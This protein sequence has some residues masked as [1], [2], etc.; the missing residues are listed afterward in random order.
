VITGGKPRKTPQLAR[1]QSV[2]QWAGRLKPREWG[3]L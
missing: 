1:N 3:V 2:T